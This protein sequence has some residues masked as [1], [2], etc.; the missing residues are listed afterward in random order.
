MDGVISLGT[1]MPSPHVPW[2]ERHSLEAVALDLLR[3]EV[4]GMDRHIAVQAEFWHGP[5]KPIL[6]DAQLLEKR[7]QFV[8]PFHP[9]G[10]CGPMRARG[11]GHK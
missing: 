8:L 10:T 6:W 5:L 4:H 7:E 9:M 3:R 2:R 11:I 1:T